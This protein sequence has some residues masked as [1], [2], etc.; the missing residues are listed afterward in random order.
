MAPEAHGCRE[1]DR[2]AEQLRMDAAHAP[3]A[4]G[5][6]PP[7]PFLSSAELVAVL[8]ARHLRYDTQAPDHPGNDHFIYAK[9]PAEPMLYAMR[10]A[11]GAALDTEVARG[12]PGLG[13]PV[14]VGLAL[15]G[16]DLDRLPYRVWVLCGDG[17]LADGSIWEAFEHAGDEGLHLLTTIVDVNGPGRGTDSCVRRIRACGWHTVEV[18]GHDTAA[19]DTAFTAAEAEAG[20]PTAVIARTL[21]AAYGAA[22]PAG[23]RGDAAPAAAVTDVRI[24]PRPPHHT[25]ERAS[26]EGAPLELPTYAPGCRIA[27]RDAY[28]EAVAAVGNARPEVVVLDGDVQH[29]TRRDPFAGE[30]PE[31]FFAYDVPARQQ[32]ST[33]IGMRARGWTLYVSSLATLLTRAH[34]YLRTATIGGI[35]L[36]VI[37]SNSG[38]A[39]GRGEP[40]QTCLEDVAMFRA[41][42]GSTVLHPCDANQT[43]RLT[44]ALADSAAGGVRYLRTLRHATPVVY[45]PHEEFPVGGSRLLRATD[46]DRATVVAAGVAVHEALRAADELA[47]EDVRVRVIDLYSVKPVDADALHKAAAATGCLLTVEDHRP[48]GGLGDAVA[49][50]FADGHPAPCMVRLAVDTELGSATP[51]GRLHEAGIDSAAI[52]AALRRL[53][54]Q[55]QGREAGG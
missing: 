54:D 18:D 2:L 22:V 5:A 8:L 35:P 38:V 23:A 25:P 43:A 11:A 46:E 1:L 6:G 26:R 4:A 9:G 30:H 37:G 52:A 21:T 28:G 45:G 39:A 24:R 31:R 42:H 13:L 16:R 20:R 34:D 3:S 19:I 10:R 51:A 53:T 7:T 27:T 50:V 14:G 40:A 36:N 32:V 29:S 41:L 15:A 44:A 12:S 17:E 49:G 55:R 33:A 48:E 47:A